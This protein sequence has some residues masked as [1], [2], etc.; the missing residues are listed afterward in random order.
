[1]F[2]F[3]G[4]VAA[5]DVSENMNS[6]FGFLNS[7]EQLF[8]ANVVRHT[9]DSL[10]QDSEWRAMCNEN[11][12]ARRNLL[13]IAPQP[14]TRH[15]KRPIHEGRLPR[16]PIDKKS[17]DIDAGILQVGEATL[18]KQGSRVCR[19]SFEVEIVVPGHRNFMFMGKRTEP[20]TGPRNLSR[21]SGVGEVPSDDQHVAVGDPDLVVQAVRVGNHN[22][23][24]DGYGKTF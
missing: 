2:I 10:I 11:V 5:M 9:G 7:G 22:D 17:F 20:H 15:V 6:R 1:M 4:A 18:G 14:A 3:R 8:A 16:A 13:P 12:Q 24:H 21:F 23:F 19:L